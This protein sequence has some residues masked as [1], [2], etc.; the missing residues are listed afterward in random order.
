MGAGDVGYIISGIKDSSEVKV[1]D[2]ITHVK[3]PCEKAISGFEDVKPMVFAGLYPV[4]ADE[5]EDLRISIEKLQL[6]DAS[7]SFVP[8]SSAALGFGFRCGFLGLLHMEIIQERLDREFDM[9]VITTVPNVSFKVFTTKGEEIDVHNPSGC[10]WLI[11]LT[12]SKNH[13]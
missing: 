5:Y 6:N 3:N 8:E 10:L 2:T 12:A 13:I 11:I 9:D 7:L 4:D 1:G